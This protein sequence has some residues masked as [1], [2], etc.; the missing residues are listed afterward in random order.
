MSQIAQL[1]KA[2]VG[3]ELAFVD[4][5]GWD[6]HQNQEGR[7]PQLLGRY[8]RSIAAFYQDLGDRMEDVM[9][10]TMS[11]FG[12]TARENGSAGT[13]H[14]KATVMFLIGDSVKGGQVYGDWPGLDRELLNENR[15]LAMTTDFRDVFAEVLTGF[16]ECEK[17]E[18]VFPDLVLDPA[19]Y[20]GVVGA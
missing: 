8:S 2:D 5:G 6:T 20:K 17:P 13:D 18:V 11:E 3:L 14:G 16:L 15:D 10:L 1:I 4:I 12:R 9:I 7:F 19:R